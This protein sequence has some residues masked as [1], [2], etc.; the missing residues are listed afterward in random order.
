MST[1]FHTTQ[2]DRSSSTENEDSFYIFSAS[3]S[4]P[5]HTMFQSFTNL[6]QPDRSFSTGNEDC[7]HIIIQYVDF[8]AIP[9]GVFNLPFTKKSTGWQIFLL[10]KTRTVATYTFTFSVH[11]ISVCQRH[12]YD[13]WIVHEEI[14]GMTDLPL[15]DAVY[16]DS[17]YIFSASVSTPFQS[18]F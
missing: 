7:C 11:R 10:Q 9:Y 18:M 6:P 13:V 8:N 3:V 17:F 4:T 14:Y 15:Q 2:S 12:S 1:P 16:A 5:F